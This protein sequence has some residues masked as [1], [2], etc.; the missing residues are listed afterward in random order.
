[1]QLCAEVRES[2]FIIKGTRLTRDM[3]AV[4][5][6]NSVSHIKEDLLLNPFL[7]GC[8]RSRSFVVYGADMLY[9]TRLSHILSCGVPGC[10]ALREGIA[11]CGGHCLLDST[12]GR[13]ERT[14]AMQMTIGA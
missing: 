12:G 4:W 2:A 3:S 5:I 1:M 8:L 6:S 9:E 7:E 11:C 14:I 13:Q 10:S